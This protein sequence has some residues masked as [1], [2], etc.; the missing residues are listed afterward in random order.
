MRIAIR[1]EGKFVCAYVAEMGTM[2]GAHLIGSISRVCCEAD[3][4]VFEAFKRAVT[5]AFAVAL[6]EAA[7]IDSAG[8]DE[9]P[10][11]E[12]ERAGDA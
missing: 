12:H 5:L 6:R 8:F 9:Q 1:A 7:G 3:P 2:E 10:A 11:P 4:E